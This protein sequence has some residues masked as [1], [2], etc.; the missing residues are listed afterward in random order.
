M[1]HHQHNQHHQHSQQIITNSS[2]KV[3]CVILSGFILPPRQ[4]IPLSTAH[5]ALWLFQSRT[6]AVPRWEVTR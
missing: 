3:H 6:L 5:L 4:R 1:L 2:F